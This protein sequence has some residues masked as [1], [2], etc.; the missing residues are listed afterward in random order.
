VEDG[1]SDFTYVPT[2]EEYHERNQAA[3]ADLLHWVSKVGPPPL[4][5]KVPT[6][7]QVGERVYRKDILVPDKLMGMMDVI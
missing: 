2:D 7:K 5:T 4:M 6:Y 1:H 3:I